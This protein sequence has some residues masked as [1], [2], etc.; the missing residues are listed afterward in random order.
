M[1]TFEELKMMIDENHI[2][3]I[4]LK[5][6]PEI[7][8]QYEIFRK[9]LDLNT[10][11]QYIFGDKK[12]Y[13]IRRNDFPYDISQNISHSILWLKDESLNI[14][15]LLINN[16]FILDDNLIWFRNSPENRSIKDIVHY[17]IFV[18]KI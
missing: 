15:E 11:N 17:H 12:D 1:I 16:N 7:M 14:K 3:K 13:I 6:K 10:F 4:Q 8:D 18:N 9:T 2:S 5:R